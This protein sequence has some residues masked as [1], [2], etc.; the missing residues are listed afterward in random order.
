MLHFT[1]DA[2]VWFCTE[3]LTYLKDDI[4]MTVAECRAKGVNAV[5]GGGSVEDDRFV[6]RFREKILNLT[7]LCVC[8]G[9]NYSNYSQACVIKHNNTVMGSNVI[10][11]S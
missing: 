3:G 10:Y 7:P 6:C 11:T 5:G 4:L 8:G 2:G 1:T 9:Y